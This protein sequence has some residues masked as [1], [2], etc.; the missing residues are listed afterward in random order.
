MSSD[1]DPLGGKLVLVVDDDADNRE[2][3]ALTLEHFGARVATAGS[4]AE[5]LLALERELPDVLVSDIGLPGEDGFSLLRRIRELPLARG[6]GVP[7]IALTGRSREEGSV[8]G[9][10]GFDLHLTKPVAPEDVLAA[11]RRVLR[12]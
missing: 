8:S 3:L 12:I 1:G 7:A 9:G 2:M 11:I 10:E 4:A 5:A 6:G